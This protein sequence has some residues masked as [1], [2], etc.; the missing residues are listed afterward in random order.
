MGPTRDGKE[1]G[2]T[3]GQ[4]SFDFGEVFRAWISKSLPHLRSWGCLLMA[5]E[6]GEG[7]GEEEE[8][9]G[10]VPFGGVALA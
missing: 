4:D 6:R 1:R 3:A 5:K 7:K 8:D 10:R 9:E 2:R